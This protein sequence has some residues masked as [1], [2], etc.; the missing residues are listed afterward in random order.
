MPKSTFRPSTSPCMSS[1]TRNV[2][3]EW[4]AL[5]S[6]LRG[7]E[8]SV[9]YSE[10]CCYTS[11]CRVSRTSALS[12]FSL[13]FCCQ[14]QR[15]SSPLPIVNVKSHYG[16]TVQ[17]IPQ[18]KHVRRPLAL[19]CYVGQRAKGWGNFQACYCI[20]KSLQRVSPLS[21]MLIPTLALEPQHYA[22]KP[23]RNRNASGKGSKGW[24]IPQ[25]LTV[26]VS[27][28]TFHSPI[29]RALTL[30]PS[31]DLR[32]LSLHVT[33]FWGFNINLRSRSTIGMRPASGAPLTP[34]SANCP[35]ACSCVGKDQMSQI[36]L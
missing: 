3:G 23:F 5:H 28:G 26:H 29:G 34:H 17:V 32:P 10:A 36:S 9:N 19:C 35:A 11:K 7:L 13:Y 1:R 18:Q 33:R 27:V 6:N 20:G 8:W 30:L 25:A 14:S 21:I 22:S 16:I 15:P 12:L 24:G 31:T 2:S 4:Y